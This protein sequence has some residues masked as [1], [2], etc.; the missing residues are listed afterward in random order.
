MKT[1]NVT[2]ITTAIRTAT[3]QRGEFRQL[4]RDHASNANNRTK[5]ISACQALLNES[6]EQLAKDKSF[7][8]FDKYMKALDARIEAKAKGAKTERNNALGLK[9]GDAK[10]KVPFYHVVRE[11][12]ADAICNRA[13]DGWLL[14][15]NKDDGFTIAKN[16]KATK[17]GGTG[18]GSDKEDE[19]QVKDSKADSK[20]D[21]KEDAVLANPLQ[22]A[23]AAIN[24]MNTGDIEALAST[25]VNNTDEAT[26]AYKL[27]NAIMAAQIDRDDREQKALE[28]K[29]QVADKQVSYDKA[30]KEL[31]A[32]KAGKKSQN[33]ISRLAKTKANAA[34]E[35]TAAQNTIQMESRRY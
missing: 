8:S 31:D 24:S 34:S 20:Q 3:K 14:S 4:I 21:V 9:C 18:S 32:A 15:F 10:K 27:A 22:T 11:A 6:R 17:A 28:A 25:I 5:I 13:P 26:N 30:A 16:V 1:L 23:I 33:V 29:T 35:L 19:S 2:Q 7:A 12:L